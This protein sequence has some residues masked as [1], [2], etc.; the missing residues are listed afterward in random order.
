MW[1]AKQINF[2][3]I[4]IFKISLLAWLPCKMC[5]GKDLLMC[6]N[7]PP[8]GAQDAFDQELF[9]LDKMSLVVSSVLFFFLD[10]IEACIDKIKKFAT[11]TGIKVASIL[12]TMLLGC[13]LESAFFRTQ[14]HP[15][16]LEN[17]R[18]LTHLLGPFQG[19]V[20]V[21]PLV[22]SVETCQGFPK[23]WANEFCSVNCVIER[24]ERCWWLFI[25]E[26]VSSGPTFNETAATVIKS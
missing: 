25:E 5:A 11:Y 19:K 2:G 18:I 10:Q 17:L 4:Y 15:S 1:G 26:N 7:Q 13:C 12:C 16:S 8:E 23:S 24:L 22:I 3:F 9:Y 21:F 14:S 20:V 6:W